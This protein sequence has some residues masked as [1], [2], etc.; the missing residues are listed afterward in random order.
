[1]RG[2]FGTWLVVVAAF[3]AGACGD[4]EDRLSQAEFEEEGNAIC[5]EGNAQIEELFV[6]LPQDRAPT[7]EEVEEF[8][9]AFIDNIRGQIDG[10][11]D[12][13]PP[14]EI[15]DEVDAFIEEAPRSP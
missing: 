8:F 4:E 1:M 12:L 14:E 2:L 7:V 10:V 6:E 13:N 3:G 5:A 9:P 11:A 15:Q